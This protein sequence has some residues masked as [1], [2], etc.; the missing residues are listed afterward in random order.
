MLKVLLMHLIYGKKKTAG[1]QIFPETGD[2]GDTL[3]PE[4]EWAIEK[5]STIDPD[6][7]AAAEI[8][9]LFDSP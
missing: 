8:I 9:S 2:Y 7:G 1:L 5:D 3:D 4:D 6:E